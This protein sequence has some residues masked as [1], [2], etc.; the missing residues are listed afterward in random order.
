VT[1]AEHGAKTRLTLHQGVF[2]TVAACDSHKG[3]WTSTVER[4]ADYLANH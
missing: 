1:F 2:E 4:L 3:G